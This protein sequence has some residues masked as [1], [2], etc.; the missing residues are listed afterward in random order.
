M[1]LELGLLL[2]GVKADFTGEV[3]FEMLVGKRKGW[4]KEQFSPGKPNDEGS[5][6]I[7]CSVWLNVWNLGKE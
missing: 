2:T 7:F 1:S 4:Q 3:V 5:E 6:C